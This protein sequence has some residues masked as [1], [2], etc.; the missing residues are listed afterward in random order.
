MQDES[1]HRQESRTG[2]SDDED[3]V[4]DD[5]RNTKTLGRRNAMS[6]HL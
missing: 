4:K 1:M 2:K 3:A 5:D 6:G